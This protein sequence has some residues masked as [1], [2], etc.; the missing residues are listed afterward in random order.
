MFKN[1]LLCYDGSDKGRRAL[2][3]GA[4][5]AIYMGSS[6]SLLAIIP[7]AVNEGLRLSGVT[8]HMCTVDVEG[9][10]RNILD[11]SIAWLRERGVV[12][13]PYLA[14]GEAIETIVAHA[15]RLSSDL[16]VVG[17]YPAPGTTRW[18]SGDK[19][20]SLAERASCSVFISVGA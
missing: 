10:Y 8:G 20:A 18:W 12:A 14:H 19:R 2:R 17:Q 4:E 9:G 7:P 11:E 5:L 16:I 6:V 15:K 3:H 13:S 1:V